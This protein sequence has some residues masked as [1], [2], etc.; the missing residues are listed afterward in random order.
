M[1]YNYSLLNK[2]SN[3]ENKLVNNCLNENKNNEN[4]NNKNNINTDS[5]KNIYC[6]KSFTFF[7]CCLFKYNNYIQNNIQNN[8]K[9]IYNN[10][11]INSFN[12]NNSN[13]N[14]SNIN[15]L[16]NNESNKQ[17]ENYLKNKRN[18]NKNIFN[19]KSNK[20]NDN[21]L[22]QLKVH[23]IL[24]TVRTLNDLLKIPK[25][26]GLINKFLE[27][28]KEINKEFK[29]KIGKSYNLEN[30]E[31]TIK[32]ILYENY[33]NKIQIKD[34]KTIEESVKKN[35]HENLK[36]IEQFLNLTFKELIQIYG[37]SNEEF[38]EKF[39]FENQY[40]LV[41]NKSKSVLENKKEIFK[42]INKDP[43]IYLTEKNERKKI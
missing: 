26:I 11:Y 2:E 8:K 27:F 20:I 10:S 36:L 43:V 38:K 23:T 13:N 9:D 5:L 16:K 24:F 33:Q 35:E 17:E 3:N 4:C 18:R 1:S 25:E 28:S 41:N 32:E 34:L 30:F 7:N 40:L 12:Y 15:F 14:L 37:M 19:I 31:K 42:L 29:E 6:T 22:K 39:K 21:I